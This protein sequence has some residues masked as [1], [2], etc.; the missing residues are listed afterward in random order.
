MQQKT[1]IYKNCLITTI[2]E[3]FLGWIEIDSNS[4]KLISINKGNTDKEGIDC[5]KKILMPGFVDSHTHG[6][7]S[8][9]FNHDLNDLEKY[10]HYLK[11]LKKEGVVA[12]VG[13]S[14]TA[15]L[16]NLRKDLKPIK[17]LLTTKQESLPQMVGWYFEGPFISVAKKGAHEEALIMQINEQFLKDVKKEIPNYPIIF[18]VDA[19][20]EENR[21]LIEKYQDDFIFA[22]GHSNA[23]YEEAKYC[24]NHGIK[25]ITHLYNAMSGFF[26]SGRLGILNVMFNGEFN[27]NINIELISDGFHVS[28]E[29]IK[30]AYK[31]FDIKNLSII[32]D[33]LPAKGLEDGYYKLGDL[34]IEKK[35]NLFYLKGLTTLAG[36]GSTYNSILNNFKRLTNCT[37]EEIVRI[38]SY[39][40]S[41]NLG[42][43]DNYGDFIVGKEINFVIVDEDINIIET[44]I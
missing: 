18:T 3:Q 19:E 7:W 23:N 22:L 31:C 28:N 36:S 2:K 1:L 41:R 17:K 11:N 38:S 24:L 15:T 37:W 26:H 42:L 21:V 10:D 43:D 20:Q 8:Y 29:A 44:F 6:G 32:T 27:K 9:S 34:D 14:V 13:T 30:F 25:R 4:K 12:F 39:N 33:S 35:G 40:T 16:D 5:N